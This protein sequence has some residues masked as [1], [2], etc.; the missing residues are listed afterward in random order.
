MAGLRF[1]GKLLR[2]FSFDCPLSHCQKVRS[3]G[4]LLRCRLVKALLQSGFLLLKGGHL[5][6]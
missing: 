3:K 6:F 2:V 4:G 5:R 1:L